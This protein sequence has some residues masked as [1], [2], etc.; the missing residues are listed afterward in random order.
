MEID[1]GCCLCLY[2]LGFGLG[3]GFKVVDFSR[4]ISKF[5]LVLFKKAVSERIVTLSANI[6]INTKKLPFSL[7]LKKIL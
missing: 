7:S 4:C 2:V 3:S 1:C 6:I 5:S